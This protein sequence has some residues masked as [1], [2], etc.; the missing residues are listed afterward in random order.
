MGQATTD[1]AKQYMAERNGASLNLISSLNF[2]NCNSFALQ[3]FECRLPNFLLNKYKTYVLSLKRCSQFEF[4][5]LSSWKRSEFQVLN[6]KPNG[7]L[8]VAS[9]SKMKMFGLDES[10]TSNLS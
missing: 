9:E 3:I 4:K 2:S 8:F 10:L 7:V 1:P 5:L 6:E